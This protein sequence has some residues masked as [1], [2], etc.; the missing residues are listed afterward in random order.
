M[1]IIG[2]IGR[3]GV[4]GMFILAGLAKLL[5]PEMSKAMLTDGGLTPTAFFHPA[6]IIFEIGLGLAVAAGGRLAI[7][8][9]AALVIFTAVVNVIYHPFWQFDGLMLRLETSLFFKNVAVAAALIY[10]AAVEAQRV[11]AGGASLSRD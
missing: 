8:A 9:C 5:D 3:A 1:R 2:H 4:G 6:T 11:R 7:P 10:I